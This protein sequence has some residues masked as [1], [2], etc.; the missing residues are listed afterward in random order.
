MAGYYLG[1][2]LGGTNVKAGV[3]DGAGKLRPST[4]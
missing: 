3:T 2:D 4:A 1:L